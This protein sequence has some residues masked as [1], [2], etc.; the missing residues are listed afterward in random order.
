ML[1]K[2]Y[3]FELTNDSDKINILEDKRTIIQYDGALIYDKLDSSMDKEFRA[4]L[5]DYLDNFELKKTELSFKLIFE[6]NLSDDKFYI[7]LDVDK[8]IKGF[9]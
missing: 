3:E 6:S 1:I 8:E 2:L 9:M 5:N 4:I 7:Y